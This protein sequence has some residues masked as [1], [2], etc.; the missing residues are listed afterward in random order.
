[1]ARAEAGIRGAASDRDADDLLRDASMFLRIVERMLVLQPV[2]P[3][4]A[5]HDDAAHG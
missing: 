3:R 4:Q 5:P 2:L 1:R